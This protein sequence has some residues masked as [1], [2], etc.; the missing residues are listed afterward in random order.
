M[1]VLVVSGN[2]AARPYAASLLSPISGTYEDLS[3]Q[4]TFSWQYNPGQGGLTQLGWTF[5]VLVNGGSTQMFWNA[6]TGVWQTRQVINTDSPDVGVLTSV[7]NVWSYQ[8]PAGAF[9]NGNAY[10]WAV[11]CKDANGLGVPS[12]YSLVTGQMPPVVAVFVPPNTGTVTTACPVITWTVA[13]APGASQ[14]TYEV[15]ICA[16]SAFTTPSGFLP[17]AIPFAPGTTPGGDVQYIPG[18]TPTLY[19]SGVIGSTTTTFALSAIP[20]YLLDD[21]GYYAF[22]QVT[23]TNNLASE[24]AYASFVTNYV[25]PTVNPLTATATTYPGVG[26]PAIELTAPGGMVGSAIIKRS[27][28]FYVR[29]ASPANPTVLTGG[30]LTVYDLEAIPNTPYTY[31]LQI[32]GGTSSSPTASPLQTSNSVTLTTTG[33]WEIN[34]LN[35][36]SS[37]NAQ[38]IS[39][40]PQI[41]EQ[42]TAHLVMGQATPNVVASVMGGLDG[43][44]TFETFDPVTYTQVQAM[45][46]SQVTWWVSS[47]W[48]ASDS[49]YVRFGPQTGGMS[50]GG[51]NKVHDSTLMPSTYESMH[52]T[53]AVTWV[54]QARPAV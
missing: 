4:P 2:V 16:A 22:V 13:L 10:Q 8:F 12:L 40:E 5:E 36:L 39:W 27:D 35:P 43:Q 1:G 51:G 17:T 50:S 38:L 49:T 34:P 20:L 53:T 14:L 21:T 19:D 45:L 28:G 9:A 23:E 18:I 6:T 52:R 42:S 32:I 3:S 33:W 41:T 11:A 46:K 25:A 31:T 47:P 44:G 30:A 7:G 48:G 54:A 15:V 24:W 37:V 26:C 29:G